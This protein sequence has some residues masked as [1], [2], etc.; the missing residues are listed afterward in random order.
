MTVRPA[1]GPVETA[2]SPGAVLTTLGLRAVALEGGL[3]AERQAINR[4]SALPHGLRMLETAGNLDNL[5]I[6]AGR[7]TGRFRGRVFMDSDVY[8]WLEA[9]A[10]EMARV[11]SAELQKSCDALIELVAAAQGPDGY[12]NSYYTVAEPGKRWS[13]LTHGHEL[14]C[15]GHLLQAAL[16]LRRGSG[17]ARLL[18]VAT[19]FVDYVHSVFGPGRRLTTDGH[20]EIEMALVEL[21]RE[22]GERRHLDLANFLLDQRGRDRIGPNRHDSLAAFQDRVPVREATGVEG[23]AVRAL[24]LTTGAADVYLETGEAALLTALNRQWQD[25]VGGK[26]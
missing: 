8:K 4:R 17:D 1:A 21:Y 9:A 15:L 19:R 6:A 25:L 18:T 7:A 20:A 26:L 16:A 12:L 5:R 3:L 22:T 2:H 14:Y 11:P 10:F 13:D 24:Y 23:H